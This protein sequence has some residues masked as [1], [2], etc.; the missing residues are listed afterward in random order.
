[1]TAEPPPPYKTSLFAAYLVDF[2]IDG[3]G[4]KPGD[5]IAFFDPQG[6]LCGFKAVT[7]SDDASALLVTVYGDDPATPAVDEGAS[8]GDSLTVKILQAAPGRLIQGAAVVLTPGGG[9][10]NFLPSPVPPVWHDLETRSLKVDTAPHF[11][12]PVLPPNNAYAEYAGHLTIRG[13]PADV[14]DEVAV[15]DPQGVLCAHFRVDTPGHYGFLYVYG[16]DPDTAE[17]DEGALG[18]DVLTFRIWDRSAGIEYAGAD[19]V[20]TAG[21]PVGDDGPSPLPPLWSSGS[22]YLLDLAVAAAAALPGD[23]NHDN[24][25]DLA[26]AILALRILSG[27]PPS[28]PSLPQ[29]GDINGD[30]RIGIEEVLFIL[31]RVGSLR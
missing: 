7:A 1:V 6:V 11:S 12:L 26:D 9:I 19:I 2:R 22:V 5:L 13:A 28:L 10:G 27:Q 14:G 17:V 31:Q 16:D 8:E 21:P 4:A 24:L 30:G 18:G 20:F 23:I 3:S 15:Y 29:A 25:V